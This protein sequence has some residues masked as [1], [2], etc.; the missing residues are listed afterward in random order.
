MCGRSP[1]KS[2]MPTEASH[3]HSEETLN[4]MDQRPQA[5]TRACLGSETSP[6]TFQLDLFFNNVSKPSAP[7]FDRLGSLE[8]D[9]NSSIIFRPNA[10]VNTDG[11]VLRGWYNCLTLAIYGSVDRVVSHDRDSPPPPPPP[12]PPPQQPTA[13]KRTPKL[14]DGEKEDQFNGSPPRP[15]P[16]GPRTP[17]GPPPPDDDEDEPMPVS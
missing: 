4:W 15:Q 6:H 14:A 17:P 13:L 5:A 11:L 2:V 3:P 1:R 7:V 16:R 9:E 12:P 8:Y 10:K